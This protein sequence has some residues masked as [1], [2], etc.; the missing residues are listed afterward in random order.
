MSIVL[1]VGILAGCLSRFCDQLVDKSGGFQLIQ[2]GNALA[3]TKYSQIM[4]S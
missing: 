2:L 4:E 3:E 1:C